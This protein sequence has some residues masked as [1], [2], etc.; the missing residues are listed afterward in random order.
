MNG[1]FD[2]RHAVVTGAASGIGRAIVQ[3]LV[4]AG[5]SVVA[6]DIDVE[7]LATLH[8]ELG[9]LVVPVVSDVTVEDEVAALVAA[10]SERFGSVDAMFNV[11]G[12]ARV[13]PLIEMSADDWDFTVG[14]CL[15]GTFFGVKHAGRAMAAQGGGA[16]VNIASLNARVPMQFNGAY[17]AAKAA[18]VS[19][20][21]TA[22]IEL[23]DAGVRVNAVLPG[24]TDTP[25]SAP[26]VALPA[27]R[28]AFMDRIPLRRA[29]LP[30]DIAA[31]AVFLA[32]DDASYIT[33]T[34]L[35]VDGGWERTAYPDL[36][37]LFS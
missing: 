34:E 37:V 26:M 15:R 6:G 33:G 5:A 16:I 14:L 7:G 29:A 22:A 27:A 1:P 19:L 36:R 35:V 12:G 9:R 4:A 3:R 25:L 11:A 32:G 8:D 24:L 10:C 21:H 23:G 28:Q 20:T 18:V 2:G 30:D 31:A 17:S 13:A